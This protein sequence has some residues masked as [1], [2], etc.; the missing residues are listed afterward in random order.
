MPKSSA[1]YNFGGIMR[2]NYEVGM[3][4]VVTENGFDVTVTVENKETHNIFEKKESFAGLPE[5]FERLVIDAI[6]ECDK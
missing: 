2:D 5:D 4:L 6:A 1:D 3:R